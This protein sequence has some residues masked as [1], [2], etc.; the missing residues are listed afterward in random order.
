MIV[1]TASRGGTFRETFSMAKAY[2]EARKQHGA[3]ALL[4]DVVSTNPK[5]DRH[6]GSPAELETRGLGHL[7][8]AVAPMRPRGARRRSTSTA[9]SWSGSP[10]AW[11][12]P[13]AKAAWRS[14]TPS[15]LRST[16]SK[17]RWAAAEATRPRRVRPPAVPRQ[18]AQAAPGGTSRR[19]RR[20][21]GARAAQA[22]LARVRLAVPPALATAVG[23]DDLVEHDPDH[24]A[25]VGPGA[26]GIRT[27]AARSTRRGTARRSGS[28]PRSR[29][30]RAH[31]ATARERGLH[32]GDAGQAVA[33]PVVAAQRLPGLPGER[34]Q[35]EPLR[36][37]GAL[38]EQAEV[39]VLRAQHGGERR[40]DV[41]RR[42][43]RD[44]VSSQ[45]K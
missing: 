15:R 44:G 13:T 4:D 26:D 22:R 36:R 2:T 3:S 1:I 42:A 33:A 19:R 20:A 23:A 27:S 6:G 10:S 16:R 25:T 40:V 35:H 45:R 38:P 8:D 12:M 9:A 11:P 29:R 32:R 39:R 28:A 17:R 37:R 30:P 7:R 14:R 24:A 31:R 41:L 43:R 18:P 5:V 34:L 21:R